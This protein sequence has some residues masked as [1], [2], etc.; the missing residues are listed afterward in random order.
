VCSIPIPNQQKSKNVSGNDD[1]FA[2][3][4]N[5]DSNDEDGD[6]TDDNYSN[7][8]EQNFSRKSKSK[9][10]KSNTRRQTGSSSYRNSRSQHRYDSQSATVRSAYF[11]TEP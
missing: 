7:E 1:A 3:D 2:D 4:E 11:G 10:K 8:S 6:Y 9:P 5:Y